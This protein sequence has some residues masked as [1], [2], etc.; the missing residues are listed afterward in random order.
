MISCSFF[1]YKTLATSLLCKHL[2]NMNPNKKHSVI[3]LF[4]DL[5]LGCVVALLLAQLAVELVP[6]KRTWVWVAH[7]LV[8]QLN[9][10]VQW[11]QKGNRYSFRDW[12]VNLKQVTHYKVYLRKLGWE[13]QLQWQL[14]KTSEGTKEVKQH[15]KR[16]KTERWCYEIGQAGTGVSPR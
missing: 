8:S 13:L 9:W 3:I 12:K 14:N 1:H 5:I 16:C 11:K 6:L 4:A 10:A 7:K 15:F 2:R